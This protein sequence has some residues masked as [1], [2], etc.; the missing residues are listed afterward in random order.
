MGVGRAV[1]PSRSGSPPGGPERAP[2]RATLPRSAPT[3]R[4]APAT[5]SAGEPPRPAARAA[6]AHTRPRAPA[7]P[8][9]AARSSS[10]WSRLPSPTTANSATPSG[11][12]QTP[13][14]GF[15]RTARTRG[16]RWRTASRPASPRAEMN[17]TIGCRPAKPAAT[18]CSEPVAP[19]QLTGEQPRAHRRDQQQQHRP[20]AH[21][22]Q[23]VEDV[24]ALCSR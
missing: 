21:Q 14:A 15:A 24:A 23:A 17:V 13:L 10:P 5:A 8:P 2:C 16:S 20:Q 1:A 4:A 3:L 9:A 6:V 11:R 18:S 19:E 7:A 12:A 22:V